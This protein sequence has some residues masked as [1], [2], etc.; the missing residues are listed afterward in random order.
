[1][2]SNLSS[3]GRQGA[4]TLTQQHVTVNAIQRHS[5]V[6]DAMLELG[7]ISETEHAAAT[8]GVGLTLT[9]G[10]QGCAGA[11]MAT[12]FCDYVWHLILNNPAYGV[13]LASRVRKLSH[14]G[15]TINPGPP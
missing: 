4:S 7:K 14:G 15:L 6:L 2:A 11:E 3:G 8:T 1:M 5:L 12:Y 9:P 13:D 10:K